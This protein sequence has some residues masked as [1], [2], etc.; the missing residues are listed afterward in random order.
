MYDREKESTGIVRIEASASEIP[1]H[2]LMIPGI[3]V[4]V[5]ILKVYSMIAISAEKYNREQA[6]ETKNWNNIPTRRKEPEGK[7]KNGTLSMILMPTVPFL[8][9]QWEGFEPSGRFWQPHD[10]QSCSL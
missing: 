3:S 5:R 6:G 1:E 2:L 9:A 7:K 10:F 4:P 8:L